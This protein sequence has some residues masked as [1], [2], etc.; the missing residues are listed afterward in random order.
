[1]KY[2]DRIQYTSTGYPELRM[3]LQGTNTTEAKVLTNDTPILVMTCGIF[4]CFHE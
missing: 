2:L 3:Q 4:K 1:M